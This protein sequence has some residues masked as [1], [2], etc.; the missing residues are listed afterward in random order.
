[1]AWFN[2]YATMERYEKGLVL[3]LPG[4]EGWSVFNWLV[5][6]GLAKG[7]VPYALE[8]HDWTTGF[9]LLFLWHLVARRR[10]RREAERVAVRIREYLREHPGRPVWVVGQSG[11]GGIAVFA[12]EALRDEENVEGAVLL[13][14]ALGQEYDLTE[15]LERTTR[16]IHHYY[17]HFDVFFQG[18]GTGIFG[19][20]DRAYG[21][22]A[23]RRGFKRPANLTSEGEELY[24]SRL[25]QVD[26]TRSMRRTGHVGLHL[27]SSHPGFIEQVVA[28]VILA[29]RG[30]EER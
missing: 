2:K 23:G 26:C 6:E 1:M 28:P 13:A 15:S 11:G 9:S 20:M 16:G 24:A 25:F 22:S 7:G 10:S 12:L 14:P 8:I 30:E 3:I 21:S 27:T 5:A 4:I 19:T 29:A 17:S 18:L